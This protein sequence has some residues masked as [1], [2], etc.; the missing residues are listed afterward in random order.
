MLSDLGQAGEKG[1]VV[2]FFFL[3]FLGSPVFFFFFVG[4]FFFFSSSASSVAPPTTRARARARTSRC[5]RRGRCACACLIRFCSRG[6]LCRRGN[7]RAPCDF[8]G[9][10][11][12]YVF[13]GDSGVCGSVF[14]G[15]RMCARV[16]ARADRACGRVFF[17]F[18]VIQRDVRRRANM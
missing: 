3:F 15:F 16:C 4:I 2:P 17:F 1:F 13:E 9:L 8:G 12:L 18:L 10:L 6:C 7:R 11:S 14:V 5:G